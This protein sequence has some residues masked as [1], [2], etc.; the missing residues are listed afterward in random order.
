M[1]KSDSLLPNI[2]LYGR[3]ILRSEAQD[4]YDAA[5]FVHSTS[6][7][8]SQLDLS[9]VTHSFGTWRRTAV[10]TALIKA[11][12]RNVDV[13][14][15]SSNEDWLHSF[16]TAHN[17]V[18]TL[19]VH[20]IQRWELIQKFEQ[21]DT[22]WN[23]ADIFGAFAKLQKA[24]VNDTGWGYPFVLYYKIHNICCYSQTQLSIMSLIKVH[25]WRPVSI[26]HD[27]HQAV[28]IQR[29][30]QYMDWDASAEVNYPRVITKLVFIIF[31]YG[32]PLY[33][34]LINR[35]TAVNNQL[36]AYKILKKIK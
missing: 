28:F 8:W 34:V 29:W 36:N 14:M 10:H 11:H 23:T 22:D 21:A 6:F 7:W 5:C 13:H 4:R 31:T 2:Y 20:T 30:K 35:C 25:T 3:F 26:K 27:D 19:Y 24:T 9:A 33:S 18:R 1:Y 32:I 16:S 17:F 15:K 12:R